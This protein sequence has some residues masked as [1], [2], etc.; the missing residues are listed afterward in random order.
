M[1]A[2]GDEMNTTETETN[3]NAPS[4]NARRRKWPM[5]AGD[6]RFFLPK[7]GSTKDKP[8]LGQ[9]MLSEKEALMRSFQAN[10]VFFTVVA[11]NAVPDTNGDEARI[12]K[13]AVKRT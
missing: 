8:E 3:N 5:G 10:Q 9:E 12:V 11:W 7:P 13:E 2:L 1:S 4:T 6:V